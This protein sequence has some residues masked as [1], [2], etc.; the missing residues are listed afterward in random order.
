M[1]YDLYYNPADDSFTVSQSGMRC[2]GISVVSHITDNGWNIT[3]TETDEELEE[4]ACQI[5]TE[6]I[7]YEASSDEFPF[8]AE[9][10]LSHETT[11][12]GAM[13]M[14][15]FCRDREAGR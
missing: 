14:L 8:F 10:T 11:E 13:A 12:R 3:G 6:R 4:M 1:T 15:T 9:V 5:A 7:S 2:F